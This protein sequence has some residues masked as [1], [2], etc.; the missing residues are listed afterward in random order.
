MAR[1][2]KFLNMLEGYTKIYEQ[3]YLLVSLCNIA[4]SRLIFTGKLMAFICSIF[5]TFYIVK[6]Y[7]SASPIMLAFFI[8]FTIDAIAFYDATCADLFKVRLV[9]HEFKRELDQ[10]FHHQLFSQAPLT[11]KQTIALRFRVKAIPALGI[12]EASFRCMDSKS[13]LAFID[14]YIEQVISL[15]LAF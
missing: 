6:H 9:F 13:M 7:R 8:A 1:K 3:Y 4:L 10:C 2:G 5:G 15:L 14:F 12:R 11:R